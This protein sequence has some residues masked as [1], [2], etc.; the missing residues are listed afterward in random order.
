MHKTKPKKKKISDYFLNLLAIVLIIFS[1]NPNMVYGSNNNWVEVSRTITGKQYWDRDS[2]R[3]KEK[4]VIE[5]STKYLKKDTKKTGGIEEMIYT[6]RINC[7]TNKYKDI[8][9][10][11]NNNLSAKWEDTNGDKL[12]NDVI[13]KSCEN[14]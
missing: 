12:I 3:N 10:N 14:V 13:Q 8:S 2:L 7:L 11:G 4:G 1:I 6:M 5:I 9:V